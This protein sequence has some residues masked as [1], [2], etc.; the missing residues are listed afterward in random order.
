MGILH[1]LNVKDGDCSIIQHPSGRVTVI[2]VC[3]AKGDVASARVNDALRQFVE[4]SSGNYQ[5]KDYP[6][7]PI[8][9]MQ[10]RG[11]TEVFRYV[12]SHPE[13][14]H[15]DGIK[16]FWTIFPPLNFWDID[17]NCDKQ[18]W[19]SNRYDQDDWEFYVQHRDG[20]VANG[21][22]RLA[23]YSGARGSYYTEGDGPGTAGDGLSILAPTEKLVA[24]ARACADYN[25][26]SYVIL[27]CTAAGKILFMGDSHDATADHLLANHLADIMDVDILIAPHHGR[28]SGRSRKFLD[29]MRPKLTLFGNAPSEHLAYD[30][31]YNR[32]LPFITNNQAGTIVVDADGPHMEIYCTNANFARAQNPNTFYSETLRAYYVGRVR[33]LAQAAE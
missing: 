14:D 2:D 7:D 4:A 5:Q 12:Q 18:G 21:P 16:R 33:S 9:Y 32:G 25:D 23:L 26:A 29:V 8:I 27:Y 1:F 6:E 30:A 19:P 24:D 11:I 22:K 15:M 17:N 20:K 31:W 13:M 28:D 3:N 10:D